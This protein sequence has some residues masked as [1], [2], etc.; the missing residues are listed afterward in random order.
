M[1]NPEG[2]SS[3][4]DLF[5]QSM[6]PRINSFIENSSTFLPSNFGLGTN[7]LSVAYV[8][9]IVQIAPMYADSQYTSLLINFGL[10]ICVILALYMISIF[11]YY[12]RYNKKYLSLFFIIVISSATAIVTEI[13]PT[14]IILC[15]LI[16]F[17]IR[18]APRLYKFR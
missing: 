4:L 10:I 2:H 13:Y 11:I 16:S 7:A 8:N 15:C 12:I 17:S 6:I 9:N 14:N 5:E 3:F 1:R 18:D